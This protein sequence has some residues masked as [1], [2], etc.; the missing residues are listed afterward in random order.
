MGASQGRV[1]PDAILAFQLLRHPAFFRPP[2]KQYSREQSQVDEGSERAMVSRE[3]KE[4]KNFIIS[5]LT[6]EQGIPKSLSSF[7]T[8]W[9]GCAAQDP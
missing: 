2:D 8:V 1:L 6:T 9:G 7:N 3:K 4:R 5:S